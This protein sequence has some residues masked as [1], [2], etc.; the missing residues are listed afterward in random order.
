MKRKPFFSARNIAYLAVLTA[1]LIVLQLFASAIPIGAGNASLNFSLVPIVLGA[2]LL[3]PLAGCFLGL[4]SGVIIFIQVVIGLTPFYTIIWT[5]SPVVAFLT[6]IVKTV[7]AG[8]VAG[9]LYR[10]VAK[11]SALAASFA[12]SAAVPVLNTGLFI[13]GC[14][15]MTDAIGNYQLVAAESD[16]A[17]ASMNIFIF[18]LIGLVSINF[19][20]ELG[21]NLVLAPAISRIEHVVNSKVARYRADREGSAPQDQSAETPE[22]AQ[23]E[24]HTPPTEDKT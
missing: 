14:L 23:E 10:L 2:I 1:L 17:F 20:I 4:L 21:I 13:L 15:C 24:P 7:V 9:F 6:C 16:A 8:L 11:K 22:A 3:G 18:I 5:Y 19:F 12:A